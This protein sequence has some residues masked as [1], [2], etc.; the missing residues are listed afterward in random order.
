VANVGSLADARSAV[1]AG[2]EGVGLF[3]TEILFLDRRTAPDEDEQFATYR[4]IAEVLAGRP[5]VIRT[6]DVGG[7]KLVPYLTQ[8][9][10]ANPFLGQ[11][12]IRLCLARPDLFRT[13]LRAI[14]RV[15]A[16]F[17][18]RM[19][20]PMVATMAE[21]R[22]ASVLLAEARAEVADRGQ[23]IPAKIETGIMIE[24][25]SAALAA[26]QFA[27]AVDFFSIGTN[28]LTQYTLAA[29][30]GNPRVAALADATQPTVLRLIER[31]VQAAHARGKW[32]SVCGEA[33]GDPLG[34]PLLIGLG[35]DELSLNSPT[36]AR[37]KQVVRSVDSIAAR[38][39]VCAAFELESAEAVRDLVRRAGAGG[40]PGA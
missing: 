31:V 28:D 24:V 12:G 27:G 34:I 10:E 20:F 3:R 17:P 11:R 2:A 29:E 33:A 8:A 15:A 14:L 21:W 22:A 26:A 13:Q 32:V 19:M 16:T 7:D 36:L 39:L 9:P 4:A 37:A 18:V 38:A 25:P 35:V 23:P 1:A 6:L 30:R 5:L 40:P